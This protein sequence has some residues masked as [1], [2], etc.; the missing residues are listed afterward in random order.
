MQ[1][2]F[3]LKEG[4][5]IGMSGVWLPDTGH[6]HVG[7]PVVHALCRADLDS[8]MPRSATI[9]SGASRSS[10]V[11][12]GHPEGPGGTTAAYLIRSQGVMNGSSHR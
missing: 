7:D 3:S 12:V 6:R 11:V 1:P 8:R 9:S 5:I 10:G 4:Q 2:G